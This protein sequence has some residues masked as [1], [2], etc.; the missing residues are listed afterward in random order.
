MQAFAE[1]GDLARVLRTDT[2]PSHA[3]VHFHMYPCLSAEVAGGPRERAGS[4]ERVDGSPHIQAHRLTCLPWRC[5][6]EDKDGR[7]N[8]GCTQWL[9]LAEGGDAQPRCTVVEDCPG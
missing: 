2:E 3:R 9:R 7:V 5:V 1:A 8:T 6:A 4:F